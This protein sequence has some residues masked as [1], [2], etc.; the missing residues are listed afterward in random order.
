MKSVCTIVSS[1]MTITAFLLDHMK[2]LSGEYH[3]SVV[4]NTERLTLLADQGIPGTV[5]PVPIERKISL[6]EDFKALRQLTSLFRR[7]RFNLIHSITPKA[8]L[9]SML[10]G[11]IAKI[12]HRLHTF[13]GQVWATSAGL[14][15]QLLK[16]ADRILVTCA[17][18][19]LV[20]SPSQ[21]SFLE[22][23]GILRR[24][25][26][27]VLAQGSISGVD[28]VRFSPSAAVRTRKRT[29]LGFED[30]DCVFLFVGRLNLDKGVMDLARAFSALQA[31]HPKTRLLFVGPDEAN[32]RSSIEDV[33]GSCLDRVRFESFTKVPEDFLR[34]ADV[35]CLPSYREGFGSVVIEAGATGIPSLA[36]RIYGVTDA[37]KDGVTGILHA[38]RA[39]NEI[40]EGMSHLAGNI[41]FRRALGD[42]AR[43]FV[44]SS[45]R[46]E[47]VTQ[48]LL[49]QYRMILRSDS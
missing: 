9:L 46:K 17:T 24:G 38:P 22:S 45:F 15:R 32:L 43:E 23:E 33:C 6:S 26:G 18:H 2:A 41:D 10:A 14:K 25:H 34:A 48:A 36:S 47:F 42:N 30:A 1:P 7:Q 11:A 40:L 8:G 3:V 4:A 28:T 44:L 21:R 31:S 13:T 19:I 16:A 12:P 27:L 37:V 5:F 49:E 35:L 39:E 20:D 29:E